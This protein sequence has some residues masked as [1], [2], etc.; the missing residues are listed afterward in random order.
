MK[1][2]ERPEHPETQT[3]DEI[4]IEQTTRTNTYTH[5]ESDTEQDKPTQLEKQHNN[6]HKQ[7]TTTHHS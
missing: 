7:T 1:H 3:T 5:S 4:N 2:S 6:I